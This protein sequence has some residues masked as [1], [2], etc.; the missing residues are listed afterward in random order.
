MK[1]NPIKQPIDIYREYLALTDEQLTQAAIVIETCRDRGI[2]CSQTPASPLVKPGLF[3]S[4][5][6]RYWHDQFIEHTAR[7]TYTVEFN[8]RYFTAFVL[9]YVID[10]GK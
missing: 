10:R 7:H 9:T 2:F 3:D 5:Y 4:A 6:T 8:L 1:I